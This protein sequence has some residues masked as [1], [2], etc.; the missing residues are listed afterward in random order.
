MTGNVGE[1]S[2]AELKTGV[3]HVSSPFSKSKSFTLDRRIRGFLLCVILKQDNRY[4][5]SVVAFLFLFLSFFFFVLSLARSL[6]QF[7]CEDF[8]LWGA[9]RSAWREMECQMRGPGA[10]RARHD[11]RFSLPR[12][13]SARRSGGGVG[14]EIRLRDRGALCFGEHEAA[15]CFSRHHSFV[16]PSSWEKSDVCSHEKAGA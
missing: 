13:D 8:N 5:T 3:R 16:C 2:Y 1:Q 9:S 10:K 4:P 11:A 12:S 7:F 14:H 15:A 6:A